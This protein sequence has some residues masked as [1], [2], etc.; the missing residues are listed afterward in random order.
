MKYKYIEEQFPRYFI[1]G[2]YNCG[3]VDVFNGTEDIAIN[4]TRENADRIIRDRDKIVDFLCEL[5]N[6]FELADAE[7][8]K[9]FWYK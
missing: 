1:F 2:E 4:V 5:A 9:S 8:F 3:N 7:D 6:V